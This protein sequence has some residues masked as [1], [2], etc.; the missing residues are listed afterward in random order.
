MTWIRR[1]SHQASASRRD[2]SRSSSAPIQKYTELSHLPKAPAIRS[3]RVGRLIIH[4]RYLVSHSSPRFL[5]Q[6]K[7]TN[8]GSVSHLNFG[9]ESTPV[10]DPTHPLA[11]ARPH[12]LQRV[13]PHYRCALFEAHAYPHAAL[14]KF[15]FPDLMI[16]L[17]DRGVSNEF[18]K[19]VSRW[20][21]TQTLPI[22]V[23]AEAVSV[24]DRRREAHTLPM[25]LMIV[26][27]KRPLHK[28]GFVRTIIKRRV[29]EALNLVVIRGASPLNGL[30]QS[31]TLKTPEGLHR[32]DVETSGILQGK[33]SGHVRSPMRVRIDCV[34]FSRLDLC[35]PAVTGSVSLSLAIAPTTPPRGPF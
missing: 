3:I 12:Q 13:V 22:S 19:L 2:A 5:F 24:G 18:S 21:S 16:Q 17:K 14:R 25:S 35:Y 7:R 1:F 20:P 9:P 8:P 11:R 32:D 29:K 4:A 6:F 33:H 26:T 28:S 31:I 23:E 15:A 27:P 34:L 10:L 30:E